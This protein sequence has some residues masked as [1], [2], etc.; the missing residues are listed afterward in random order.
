MQ[1]SSAGTWPITDRIS[2]E[3]TTRFFSATR[4]SETSEHTTAYDTQSV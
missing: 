2:G 3:S 4:S 1:P